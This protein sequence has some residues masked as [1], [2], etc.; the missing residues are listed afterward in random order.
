MSKQEVCD[1]C[2][3]ASCPKCFEG[4]KD[5]SWKEH[6]GGFIGEEYL[7]VKQMEE[8]GMKFDW[9]GSELKEIMVKVTFDDTHLKLWRQKT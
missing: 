4:C 8:R 7:T 9:D 3:G 2:K 6:T 1:V 5:D